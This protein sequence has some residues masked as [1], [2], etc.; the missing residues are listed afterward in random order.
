[1][2]FNG[3]STEVAGDGSDPTATKVLRRAD[4]LALAQAKRSSLGTDGYRPLNLLSGTFQAYVNGIGGATLTTLSGSASP[5]PGH[6]WSTSTAITTY[7]IEFRTY[8]NMTSTPGDIITTCNEGDVIW[9]DFYGTAIPTLPDAY[10]QFS[11]VNI[12]NQDVTLPGDF[13]TSNVLDPI[14][15]F[16]VNGDIPQGPAG[17]PITIN[18][19][20]LTEGNE[21]LTLTW[22]INSTTVATSASITIVDTS[23][24]EGLGLSLGLEN[25]NELGLENG[26][27]LGLN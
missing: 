2:A 21:T 6:P 10:L 18:A 7:G 5:T 12:E 23:V 9:F 13:L 24:G 27:T 8:D 11:G 20:N 4:K 26:N 19:D 17:A 22:Y 1:M 3:I 15:L 25:G 14:P 16:G